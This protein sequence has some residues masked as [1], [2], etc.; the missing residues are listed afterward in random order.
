MNKIEEAQIILQALGLPKRQQNERSALTLL[1]LCQLRENDP[2]SSSNPVSM[3]V[4]GNKKNAKYEGIMRFIEEHYDRPY[5][6]NSRET[7]RRQTLHQFVQA[8]I[9]NHNPENP[10]LPTNSKDNHYKLSPEAARVVR[11]YNTESWEK[12]LG[13]FLDKLGTLKDKYR[14]KRDMRKIPLRLPDGSEIAF[15][16]GKHN[17]VQIAIIR[18]FAPRFAPGSSL[19]YVGDTAKKD[20]YLDV[21]G[22]EAL[23][24]PIDQHSKLPD[25]V[26]YDRERNWLFLVEAVTSHGPVSP[27]RIIEMEEMM[28]SCSAGKVYVTAFQDFR[29]F[30][31]HTDRLAW[32]TEVW[33]V[34]FPDHMIHFN[35]DRFMGPR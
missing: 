24:I 8:G 28:A 19:L 1:A 6:E 20:L 9:V 31:R 27:K 22:L 16:P 2:W 33:I 5:A 23:S 32:E 11:A 34:D 12:E 10:D 3:A 29:E 21:S 7:F 17:E 14:K 13:E 30:K 4:M 35:G 26:L 15:S 25:V 18:E